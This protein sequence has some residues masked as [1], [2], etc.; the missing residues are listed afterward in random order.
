M[1]KCDWVE[2]WFRRTDAVIRVVIVVQEEQSLFE[3]SNFALLVRGS[4]IRFP[5]S[6]F[7]GVYRFVDEDSSTVGE[8]SVRLV[9]V[10]AGSGVSA[11]P[12]VEMLNHCSEWE[13]EEVEKEFNELLCGSAREKFSC[14]LNDRW[15]IR[16]L[17]GNSSTIRRITGVWFFFTRNISQQ[18]I[19][20]REI[21]VSRKDVEELW[22]PCKN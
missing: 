19:G 22:I 2:K 1:K 7:E 12:S 17:F 3:G 5:L 14:P 20:T 13:N 21:P 15:F 10:Y 8:V 4:L 6:N 11:I 9:P 16:W 18:Q